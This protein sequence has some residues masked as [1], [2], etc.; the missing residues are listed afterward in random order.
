ML[1]ILNRVR[2]DKTGLI[3]AAA[4]LIGAIIILIIGG[5]IIAALLGVI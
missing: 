1:K 4:E 3:D 2:G 5:M